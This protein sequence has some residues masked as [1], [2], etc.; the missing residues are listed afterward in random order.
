MREEA[1]EELESLQC[2]YGEELVMLQDDPPRF[3]LTLSTNPEV[4]VLLVIEYTSTYPETS[5]LVSCKRQRGLTATSI[6]ALQETANQLAQEQL[7]SVIV[8][9]LVQA[10][11][12][13]LAENAA[14][15]AEEEDED[16]G[17]GLRKPVVNEAAA[18][19]YG[20]AVTRENFFEWKKKF[21]I[22]RQIILA[23]RQQ[24]KAKEMELKKDR[25]T[26]KTYFQRLNAQIDWTLFAED[27]AD[28]GEFDDDYDDEPRPTTV[29]ED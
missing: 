2:I 11:Q 29:D 6:A 7:G 13:W 5:P 18:I 16:T 10:V 27:L 25:V 1:T 3:Q 14:A 28:D 12:D 26:G 20:T 4:S 17:G 23:A 9:A 8:F 15:A 22:E 21:D 19:K 24:A